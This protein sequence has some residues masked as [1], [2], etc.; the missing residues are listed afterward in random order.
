MVNARSF[1]FVLI[2]AGLAIGGAW[3]LAKLAPAPDTR[4]S[5]EQAALPRIVSL[6]P[7]MT[8]VLF[9]IGA[10]PL[11][12]GISDYCKPPPTAEDLPRAGTVLTPNYE[13]LARLEPTLIL[14]DRAGQVPKENLAAIATTRLLPWLSVEDVAAGIR[15]L[16]QL[17][18]RVDQAEVLAARLEDALAVSADGV[19]ARNPDAP[20]VLLVLEHRTGQLTEVWYI[21]ARSLHGA[22]LRAA[23]G[24]NA[25][26][27]FVPGPP[28][29]SLER[30]VE[31]NPDLVIVLSA[32]GDLATDQQAAILEDWRAL[33]TLR[34]V[35]ENALGLV[36]GDGILDTGPGV[37]DLVD[38]LHA[39]IERLE[40]DGVR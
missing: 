28:R 19:R 3:L 9:A 38:L 18:N 25:V 20:R 16:G 40:D 33:D 31:L 5:Q 13:A 12:V 7:A 39:E 26:T 11:V 34:A 17:T 14:G 22:V 30:V 29:L 6:S 27:E 8:D 1:L 21:K 36:A 23:G 2:L 35:R 15:A 4:S 32:R 10:D 37:L 24:L